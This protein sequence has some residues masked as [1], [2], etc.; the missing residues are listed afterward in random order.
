M[1]KVIFYLIALITL[2]LAGEGGYYLGVNAGKRIGVQETLKNQ[3]QQK[4]EKSTVNP[5]IP[6]VDKLAVKWVEQ[7]NSFPA[8]S[9]WKSEWSTVIGGKFVSMD[10]NSITLIINGSSD[11]KKILFPSPMS[12]FETIRFSQFDQKEKNYLPGSLSKDQF[13][14]GDDIGVAI[15]FETLTGKTKV[16]ELIKQINH[17]VIE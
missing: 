9:L 10:E 15:S 7:I 16:F 11:N 2:A 1:N 6:V 13:K 17:Q 8:D 5:T 12:G 4:A 3:N 14:T